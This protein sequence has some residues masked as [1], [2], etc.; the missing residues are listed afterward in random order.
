MK[1]SPPPSEFVDHHEEAVVEMLKRKQAGVAVPKGA[2]AAPAAN[3]FTSMQKRQA[4]TD[5]SDDYDRDSR[6]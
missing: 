1:L 5:K 3:A 6:D 4:H 2:A